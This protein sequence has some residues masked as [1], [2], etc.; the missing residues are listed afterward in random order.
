MTKKLWRLSISVEAV[1]SAETRREAYEWHR[2]VLAEEFA[3]RN[4][5]SI[6]A[7]RL[8]LKPIPGTDT[9]PEVPTGWILEDI[10]YED[11]Q[12]DRTLAE[13]IED[14]LSKTTEQQ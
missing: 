4:R 2:R 5:L 8:R 6:R 9:G 7:K 13:A 14:Q 1:V 10:V 3:R 12:E 11:G